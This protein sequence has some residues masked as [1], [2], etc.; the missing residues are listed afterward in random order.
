MA[1]FYGILSVIG[2]G[3]ALIVAFVVPVLYLRKIQKS[4]Q[5]GFDVSNTDEKH[6]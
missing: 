4:Q 3:W 6:L 1:K 2:W 5:Q